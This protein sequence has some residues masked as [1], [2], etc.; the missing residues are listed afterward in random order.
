MTSKHLYSNGQSPVPSQGDMNLRVSGK[1]Y[2][3][4]FKEDLKRK[5]WA[6]ALLGLAF[7]FCLPV[8]LAMVLPD[9]QVTEFVTWEEVLVRRTNRVQMMLGF[10]EGYPM[11]T[12]LLFAA[13]VVMG[14]AT[15]S[16]LQ[17]KKQID[18]YHSLPVKRSL[19]FWVNLSTGIF[20][21]AVIYFA[22]VILS[23]IVG[24][25]NGVLPGIVLLKAVSGFLLN[26][27]YYMLTYVT[28]VLAMMLT[29]TKIAAIL[30]SAVF[31][32]FFP[33]STLLIRSY[34]SAFLETYYELTPGIIM[35][36]FLRLSPISAL[37]MA[38]EEITVMRIVWVLAA[39]MVLGSVCFF[40]YQKRPS[41]AA[42]KTMAF[43]CSKGIVK[44]PL[45]MAF[46]AA[47]AMF[48]YSIQESLGWSIFGNIV[49]ILLSHCVI[50]VIF[51]GDFKKVFCHEK[52][53]AVCL[54]ASLAL[55]LSFY[56]DW[57][58]FD[59][60]VPQE[61]QIAYASVDF[62]RDNWMNSYDDYQD[63]FFYG[64]SILHQGKIED[65]SLVLALVNEAIH[66]ME[67]EEL[68]G[69]DALWEKNG[70]TFK[71]RLDVC[72]TLK[73]RRKVYRSYSLYLNPVMEA[74]N[75]IYTDAAYKQALYP[76][77]RL[78]EEAAKNIVYQGQN[79]N[80]QKLGGSEEQ[81]K[82][83]MKAY[84]EELTAL[85]FSQRR[86]ENP[87]GNLLL[88][89]TEDIVRLESRNTDGE[90]QRMHYQWGW[91]DGYFYPIYPSFTKT[92]QALESCGVE[93]SEVFTAEDVE[94]ITISGYGP[95]NREEQDE[96]DE[97]TKE[98]AEALDTDV[99]CEKT[100]EKTEEVETILASFISNERG[101]RNGMASREG[102]YSIVVKLKGKGQQ[103]F[104]GNFRT[105]EVPEFVVEDFK[106]LEKELYQKMNK[107]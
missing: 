34:Y 46:G 38:M 53:M 61:S 70:Y 85:S 71:C 14:I 76:A 97:M 35:N 37:A 88:I 43:T 59:T 64:S 15:F 92:I 87:F 91:Y 89:S 80:I 36:V 23:L 18:F 21:P 49:G 103:K 12:M 67:M 65:S 41:E 11:V 51:W 94:E 3:K 27:L 56:F 20:L 45:V 84:Q 39:I 7:F 16:Y 10:S 73:G 26:M 22:A 77:L 32:A 54:A 52:T 78:G 82:A 17:N 102:K 90:N 105:G 96:W 30:G 42:G 57:F 40:L 74:A 25:M 31:F 62:N 9:V 44:V 100:Y 29:G 33:L 55:L 13:A 1:V 68:E 50:E 75:K 60:Y 98:M 79:D 95:F 106:E 2:V 93:I 81:W 69:E 8:P 47:G 5:L 107:E 28:V 101:W 48:F 66:Q 6:A 63:S 72:Y 104:D 83:V 4:L 19:W 86:R 24:M 58:K 99:F